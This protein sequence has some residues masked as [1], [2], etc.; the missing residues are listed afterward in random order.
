[1]NPTVILPIVTLILGAVLGFVSTISAARLNHYR[2][3][4]LR[5]LDQYLE[6]R[7]QLV[8]IVSDLTSIDPRSAL[9]PIR[10]LNSADRVS[11]LFYQHYDFLPTE[12]L[13]EL[14][15]LEACLRK[16]ASGPYMM[17][18]HMVLP[19]TRDELP[20]FIGAASLY[21][22]AK[23]FAALGLGSSN[24]TVRQNT[25]IRLHA[26][27]VLQSLNTFASIQDLLQMT[28]ALKKAPPRR[29]LA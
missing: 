27:H 10:R 21:E 11:K 29:R 19:I 1:M 14:A 25:A 6:V 16:P 22:N 13:G 26:R 3:I 24:P 9:D 17:T 8:D 2:T 7:K 18:D 5:L 28:E 12:V 20:R 23:L 4:E 15:L